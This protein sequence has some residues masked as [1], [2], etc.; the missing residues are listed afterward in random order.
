MLGLRRLKLKPGP[1]L[2]ADTL[3]SK[4][5]FLPYLASWRLIVLNINGNDQ[6]A[7]YAFQEPIAAYIAHFEG[8]KEAL[9]P[10]NR[11]LWGIFDE[12]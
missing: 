10:K 5:A 6:N 4:N 1:A 7:V 12:I 3:L 9:R 2:K 11:L 8:K